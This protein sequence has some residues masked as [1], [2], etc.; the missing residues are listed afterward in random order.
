MLL[1]RYWIGGHG[2]DKKGELAVT[3]HKGYE[4]PQR[5]GCCINSDD[6]SQAPGGKRGGHALGQ[7]FCYRELETVGS[8]LPEIS[9]GL[10]LCSQILKRSSCHLVRRPGGHVR[11][12]LKDLCHNLTTRLLIPAQLGFDYGEDPVTSEKEQI[13]GP[14]RHT[15]LASDR[16]QFGRVLHYVAQP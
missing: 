12:V 10:T 9:D 11:A 1:I 14:A 15:Y 5:L 7:V 8:L 3:I 2:Q 6:E 4:A 16:N 13:N